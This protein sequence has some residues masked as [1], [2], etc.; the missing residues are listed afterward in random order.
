MMKKIVL[1]SIV[2]GVL[3]LAGCIEPTAKIGCC[4][5][6]N[7]SDGCMLLNMTTSEL[8]DYISETEWCNE[9]SGL[10]NVS[11]GDKHY[12]VPVCTDAELNECINPECTAM[13]CGDFMF[14]PKIAPGV[15][16]PEGSEGAQV[17]VPP[18]Q[19]E[20]EARI[21]F[22]KAQCKFMGMDNKLA[23]LMKNTDSDINVFRFGVGESFDEFERYKYFFPMTDKYCNAYP[24]VPGFTGTRVDRYMN[25]LGVSGSSTH[26]AFDPGTLPECI[27]DASSG[28]VWIPFRYGMEDYVPSSYCSILPESVDRSEYSYQR[29]CTYQYPIDPSMYGFFYGPS[30]RLDKAFYRKGLSIAHAETIYDET[31]SRAPFECLFGTDCYSGTCNTDYYSRSVNVVVGGSEVT[32]DCYV[33]QDMYDEPVVACAPTIDVDPDP[34]AEDPPD[35]D[36]AEVPVHLAKMNLRVDSYPGS[37]FS[38]EPDPP[39]DYS[40]GNCKEKDNVCELVSQWRDFSG[41]DLGKEVDGDSEGYLDYKVGQQVVS[42]EFE[43]EFLPRYFEFQDSDDCELLGGADTSEC[44]YITSQDSYPPAGGVVFF[45]S[46]STNP[47]IWEDGGAEYEIIGYAIAP[48]S[49]E[50]YDYLFVDRC[51]KEYSVEMP[52]TVGE[53]AEPFICSASCLDRCVESGIEHSVLID[54]C[55]D[56]CYDTGDFPCNVTG[57]II[58]AFPFAEDLIPVD[59]GPPDG[60]T[61]QKLMDTF[62]PLFMKKIERLQRI[63]WED[64]CGGRMDAPDVILSSMPWV[65]EFKK[66]GG[67]FGPYTTSEAASVLYGYNIYNIYSVPRSTD[68]CDMR[69]GK[70][71]HDDVWYDYWVLYAS[72][73]WLIKKPLDNTLGACEVDTVGFP[74]TNTYGWCEP[75]TGSTIAYEDVLATNVYIPTHELRVPHEYSGTGSGPVTPRITLCSLDGDDMN[76][77]AA[78]WITDVEELNGVPEDDGSPRTVPVATTLKERVGDYLKSGILPVLD[79]THESNWYLGDYTEYAFED[80][81]GDMGAVVVIVDTINMDDGDVSTIASSAVRD[82][83]AE[84]TGIIKTSCP[85]CM[86]AIQVWHAPDNETLDELLSVL[87]SDNRLRLDIDIVG[88][89]YLPIGYEYEGRYEGDTLDEKADSTVDDMLSFSRTILSHGK[90]SVITKFAVYDTADIWNDETSGVLFNKIADRSGEFANTGTIGIIYAPARTT[91][92]FDSSGALVDASGLQGLKGEKFCNLQEAINRYLIP[93]P[94]TIFSPMAAFESVNC[95]NCTSV[96]YLAGTCSP[97]CANGGLCDMPAGVTSGMKCPAGAL[98]EPCSLCNETPGTYSCEYRYANGSVEVRDYDYS[99]V[100]SD[101][102]MDVMGGLDEKCCIEGDAGNRYSYSKQTVTNLRNIPIVFSKTGNADIDCGAIGY[103][104]GVFSSAFCGIE[105]VPVKNYEV[106]C[107]FIPD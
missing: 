41:L 84:R 59:V 7:I 38:E 30:I 80:V 21:G 67:D 78:W 89:W 36:Y 90:A 64:G 43:L 8:E 106:E 31:T 77:D 83:I 40:V 76:C 58:E 39:E 5:K 19:E 60:V 33:S 46:D 12:L 95:T 44:P 13:V 87:F 9:T 25:Y 72:E 1:L 97:V 18:E 51:S 15:V 101:A 57:T 74:S 99:L 63:N 107:E 22:Y 53:G 48:H 14:K 55:H 17:D 49:P 102:F 11:I 61:W 91:F 34:S 88:Y 94:T 73:I 71:H 79:M 24:E 35:F 4:A 82:R 16:S 54:Q 29:F 52:E 85:R 37:A 56:Y 45:G 104:G 10:C 93:P 69:Y 26:V 28:S 6:D 96:D 92:S 98:V 23:S 65:I 3:L 32:A 105:V 62:E 20:E 42:D 47:I 86:P 70:K 27:D 50:F 100:S 68:L 2:I 66:K 103:S 75:C 81:Y